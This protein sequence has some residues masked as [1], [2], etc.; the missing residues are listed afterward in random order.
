MFEI[1]YLTSEQVN[2]FK[3]DFKVIAEFFM[4]LM[5]K[6]EYKGDSQELQHADE[7]LDLGCSRRQRYCKRSTAGLGEVNPSYAFNS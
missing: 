6:T 1:G 2:L 7:D 4:H 5:Q 3:S